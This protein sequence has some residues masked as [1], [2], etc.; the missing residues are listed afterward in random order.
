MSDP[1]APTFT[2]VHAN[3]A[4]GTATTCKY[5]GN[6]YVQLLVWK[7]PVTTGKVVATILSG[8]IIIKFGN[9]INWMFHMTYIGLLGMY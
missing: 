2:N 4:P 5:L 3:V 1:I 6:P 9:P 8:L 7:D